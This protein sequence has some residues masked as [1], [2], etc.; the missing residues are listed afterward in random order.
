MSTVTERQLNAAVVLAYLAQTGVAQYLH[1][2][3]GLKTFPGGPANRPV[4]DQMPQVIS[5]GVSGLNLQCK[6]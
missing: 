6:G 3:D 4:G 5:P 1:T 2:A